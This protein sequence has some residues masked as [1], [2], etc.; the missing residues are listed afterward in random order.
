MGKR[1]H[2]AVIGAGSWGTSLAVMLARAGIE[3]AL[4]DVSAEQLEKAKAG[5]QLADGVLDRLEAPK[6]AGGG[7]RYT[8]DL[9][10]ATDLIGTWTQPELGPTRMTPCGRGSR[11]A[12][13]AWS[14]SRPEAVRR[15]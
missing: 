5:V 9:G 6:V 11:R 7:V 15:G 3:V 10:R 14:F 12:T 2:V 4:Y 13:A 8:D 1:G